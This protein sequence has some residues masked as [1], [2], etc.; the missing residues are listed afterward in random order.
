MLYISVTSWS[1]RL[2]L[3]TT[4]FADDVG[5]IN[6][7]L[8]NFAN[9]LGNFADA[10]GNKKQPHEALKFSLLFAGKLYFRRNVS[11]INTKGM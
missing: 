11:D 2:F 6:D 1:V 10:L 5:K 7:A 9:S 3:L 4:S 8:D